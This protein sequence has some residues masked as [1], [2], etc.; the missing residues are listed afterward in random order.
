MLPFPRRRGLVF[1]PVS[2]LP[3]LLRPVDFLNDVPG[4]SRVFTSS[5]FY[6]LWLVRA[7][8]CSLDLQSMLSE[9]CINMTTRACRRGVRTGYVKAFRFWDEANCKWRIF[10]RLSF[11]CY[12]GFTLYVRVF[13][14]FSHYLKWCFAGCVRLLLPFLAFRFFFLLCLFCF[15]PLSLGLIV[16]FSWLWGFPLWVVFSHPCSFFFG[17]KGTP[18]WDG[19]VPYGLWFARGMDKK[20]V[21]LNLRVSCIYDCW[22]AE[23]A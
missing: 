18:C 7:C 5:D 13:C 16:T 11:P 6:T 20:S 22:L 14:L 15:S 23:C 21:L 10:V 4:C 17:L 3:P 1:P 8:R 19:F 2:Q 9:T 12:A